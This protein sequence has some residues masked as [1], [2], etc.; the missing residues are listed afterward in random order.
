MPLL[1]A[2][3]GAPLQANRFSGEQSDITNVY[4]QI[5]T[6]QPYAAC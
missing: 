4:L 5:N 2:F 6:V 3:Y 1:L